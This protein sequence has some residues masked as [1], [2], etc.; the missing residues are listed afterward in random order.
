MWFTAVPII[1]N[2]LYQLN[3]PNGV[4]T[5]EGQVQIRQNVT[6]RYLQN[7]TCFDHEE[8]AKYGLFLHKTVVELTNPDTGYLV[9]YTCTNGT[10][11][12]SEYESP[13]N[14]TVVYNKSVT[15]VDKNAKPHYNHA[16]LVD[17]NIAVGLMFA[18]KS[19][20][21]MCVNP[22]IGPLTNRCVL[23]CRV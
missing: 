10:F 4:S 2:F 22:F 15:T 1:P 6:I 3:H 20:V 17:E 11:E 16:D 21:Q 18:S 7:L 9:E 12:W 23:V 14:I 13:R 8:F 19:V 5:K